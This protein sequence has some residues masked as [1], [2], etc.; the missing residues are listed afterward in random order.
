M[1]TF[2]RTR[3]IYFA[4]V[5]VYLLHGI[6]R[7]FTTPSSVL[8]THFGLDGSANGWMSSG[9]FLLFHL[10]MVA[11]TFGLRWFL[12]ATARWQ[13]GINIPEYHL[14]SETGKQAFVNF[15]E[16]HSWAFGSLMI[17]F[18]ILFDIVIVLANTQS[19][20]RTSMVIGLIVTLFFLGS[21]AWWTIALLMAI[22]RIKKQNL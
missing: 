11:F 14:L 5:A 9:A 4:L 13:K 18:F 6:V 3:N 20:A 17:G 2:L 1:R 12:A 22:Q 19:F 15:M 21:V 10:F 16:H 7:F 8:A